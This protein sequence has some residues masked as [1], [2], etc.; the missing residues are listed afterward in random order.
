[1]TVRDV[2]IYPQ[3][4]RSILLA[5]IATCHFDP[6]LTAFNH[7]RLRRQRRV[8]MLSFEAHNGYITV[9]SGPVSGGI[10]RLIPLIV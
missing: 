5:A 3:E 6:M 2:G 4:N 9:T 8:Q 7:E 10:S 1:M